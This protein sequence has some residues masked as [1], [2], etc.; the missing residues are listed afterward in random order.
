MIL[1][2]RLF[3]DFK[4]NIARYLVLF[5]LI[6]AGM[7]LIVSM[8]AASDT[9]TYNMQESGKDS[10][11]ED[12]SWM[13]FFP[14]SPEEQAEI[15]DKAGIETEA[16]FYLDYKTDDDSEVRVFRVRE[17]ID[18]LNLIEGKLPGNW[19]EICV[20][21]KF[22]EANGLK[23]GSVLT[24]A[25]FEYKV[26]GICTT[27]DYE[28]VLKNLS[29][30]AADHKAFGTVFVKEELYDA[31]K[32]TGSALEAETCQYLYRFGKEH[33]STRTIKSLIEKT[34]SEAVEL[35]GME[36]NLL[37]FITA[38]DNPRIGETVNDISMTR[39]AGLIGG[40]IFLILFI[41]VISVY[42]VHS[43]EQESPVIGTLY[44]MGVKKRTLLRHYI[45]LPVLITLIAG[46]CGTAA[47]FTQLGIGRMIN[48][49]VS[50]YSL[51]AFKTVHP[52]YLLLYG[53]VMP[54]L[55]SLV[56]N[57]IVLNGKLSEMPLDLMK[58]SEKSVKVS[59]WKLK[60]VG[61]LNAFRIRQF[62]REWRSSLAIFIGVLIACLMLV[63]GLYIQACLDHM[64][65]LVSKDVQYK[66]SYLL[67]YSNPDIDDGEKVLVKNLMATSAVDGKTAFTTS[68]MGIDDSNPYFSFKPVQGENKLTV[69]SSMATKFQLKKG[70][71]ITLTDSQTEKK[72]RFQVAQIVPYSA[73][74]FSFMDIGDMRHAFDEE[75]DSYNM[76]LSDRAL[77]IDQDSLSSKI[78]KSDYIKVIDTFKSNQG[79]M[80][81]SMILL[82]VVIFFAVLY[83][84]MKIM[85]DRSTFSISMMSIL[86][87]SERLIRK[88]F[89]DSNLII[90]IISAVISLPLNKKIMDVFWPQI[91]DH[92]A[93]GL[94]VDFSIRY[95]A[96]AMAVM[97]L[98]YI[99]VRTILTGKVKKKME[100]GSS[101]ILKNRE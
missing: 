88:I 36:D 100:N 11:I 82:S 45:T 90:F 38:D 17:K 42:T 37:A 27:P 53:I 30:T 46:A 55:T 33:E 83:L 28:S 22:A 96:A 81:Y 29:D 3:R 39:M 50:D 56:V 84:M 51:P 71:W 62:I 59:K 32:A 25:G 67:K 35:Y 61:F 97:I 40:L 47:G 24:I 92:E 58:Q 21:K 41:Y 70:G 31:L 75:D 19:D 10:C 91:I 64:E 57:T 66:Y 49:L 93:I 23:T 52:L 80:V 98:S 13:T 63:M 5:V 85:I 89:L 9:I 95:Y 26:A 76:I 68:I 1:N 15:E 87:Y 2:K 79:G 74:L 7:F 101:V 16:A 86:G 99:I 69:S 60:N 77:D 94:E 65:Q 6:L 54:S 48:A 4:E 14:L 73:G 18:L 78:T 72:Y 34:Q 44:A 43:V 12:G 8:V 20:E